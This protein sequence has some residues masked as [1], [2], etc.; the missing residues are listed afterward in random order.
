MICVCIGR[1]RHKHMMAEHRFLAEE[2]IKL[3]ELRVDYIRSRL[4]IKRLLENRPCPCIITCRREQD[5]GHWEGTEEARVMALRTAIVEGADYVDLEDD[6]AG[7]I[8]RYGNTKRIVSYHN[9]RDTPDELYEIHERLSKLDADIVKIATLTHS[10]TDNLRMLRLVQDA[11]LPTIGICMGEIGTPTRILAGRFGAP[12]TYAT[13]HRD[14]KLAPGQISYKQMRNIYR[15]DELNSDTEVYGVVADPVAQNMSPLVHNAGFAHFKMNK[16][17]LPFRVPRDELAEFLRDGEELGL[18][19]LTVAIPHK[20]DVLRHLAKSDGVVRAIGAASSLV[21][22]GR[23][24]EGRNTDPKAFTE[25]L[26]TVF[27]ESERGMTLAGRTALILGAG[28]I[29][30]AIAYGLKRR[31]ANVVITSRTYE[32]SLLLAEKFNCRTVQWYERAKVEPDILIN[33]TPIGTHPNVDESP[34]DVKYLRRG[35]IVVDTVYNPEQTLLVKE[36]REQNCR[37]VTG[38]EVFVR[39][40]AKQ[41]KQFTGEEVPLDLMQTAMKRAIGPARQD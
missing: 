1:G 4:N 37:V 18:R 2:G 11:K 23:E 14:R 38:L 13:F 9:F 20:E 16:V 39:Q 40:A 31:D 29:S 36:A 27:H 25:A 17:Y 24:A 6:V 28:G 21:F 22:E 33:A 32:R 5:G 3:V 41:F 8:P 15:Y 30:K 26:D 19:G 7:Q 10:P 12:F 35:M 34:M